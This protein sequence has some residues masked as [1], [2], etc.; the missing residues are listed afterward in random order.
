MASMWTLIIKNESVDTDVMIEDLGIKVEFGTQITFS[1]QFT[2]EEIATSDDLRGYVDD[3]TLVSN[4]GTIDLTKSEGKEHLSVSHH[5][6]NYGVDFWS[7]PCNF[8][9]TNIS[10]TTERNALTPVNKDMVVDTDLSKYFEWDGA[11]WVDRGDVLELDRVINLSEA[12]EAIFEFNDTVWENQGDPGA[13]AKTVA[14]MVADTRESG[15]EKFWTYSV[16]L[17]VWRTQILGTL[18]DAY[19]EGD[20]NNDHTIIVD[21]GPVE[22]DATSGTD[23]PIHLTELSTFPTT[24]L[25]GGQLAVVGDTLYLYDDNR[26]RWIGTERTTM[27]FG[28]M[29]PT[30]DQY[31]NSFGGNMPSNNSGIPIDQDSVIVGLASRIDT[32]GTCVIH[33]YKNDVETSIASITITAGTNAQDVTINV[34]VDAGDNI[35]AYLEAT[36]AV[37]DPI[38]RLKIAPRGT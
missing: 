22:F 12:N 28:R 15:R 24:N 3:G 2:Y 27:V 34:N 11:A 36:T 10:T 38:V 25:S 21:D 5:F 4:N 8:R 14:V 30:K 16:E 19:N 1:D 18:D 17:N 20:E 29:K 6:Y 26:G 7:R 13:N 23:A 37:Q 33:I 35:S 9:V 32:T 31:L